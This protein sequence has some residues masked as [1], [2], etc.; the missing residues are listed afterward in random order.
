MRFSIHKRFS[1]HIFFFCFLDSNLDP[2][3]N[4]LPELGRCCGLH[5]PPRN[6]LPLR[7]P[8]RLGSD[9]ECYWN[10]GPYSVFMANI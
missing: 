9:L 8:I 5:A 3:E 1:L 4:I 10:F 6:R 2:L 7:N